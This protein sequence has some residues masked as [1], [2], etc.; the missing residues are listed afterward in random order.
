[1][2]G[3]DV[4]VVGAGS[5]GCVLAAR[6]T[7]N[8]D[9]QVLLLEAGPD[10]PSDA[11]PS[12]IRDAAV[13]AF[14]H[15]WGYSSE[16]S[17]AG[18]VVD[19]ARGRL[20]GGCSAVN[21]T[22]ALRGSPADYDRWRSS[23]ARG[24]GWEEV[25]PVF[26]R[27]ES[28]L[29][30]GGMPWH[31][32]TGPVPIRR[33][34]QDEL[35]P[36]PLEFLEACQRAGHDA[37]ADH[38]QPGAIGAGLLPVNAVG[39]VRQSAALTYL[40]AAR[41]RPNLSVRPHAQV[42]RLRFKGR[43]ARGVVLAGGEVLHADRVV[44]A[45][46]AYASPAILLRSGIGPADALRALGIPVVSDLPGVGHNLQDHPASTIAFQPAGKSDRAFPAYQALLTLR[47]S[48]W[49]EPEPDLQ[50]VV[51]TARPGEGLELFA[52]L[53]RP[54]SRG[55]VELRDRGALTPPR[56]TT[57]FLQEPRD[58]PRLIEALLAARELAAS[59]SLLPWTRRPAAPGSQFD[60][61]AGSIGAYVDCEHWSYFHPVGT[62]AIGEVVDHEGRVQ[63][64][65]GV[66]VVDASILPDIPSANTNLPTMMA[67]ER[68]ADAISALD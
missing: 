58:R 8:R 60:W 41:A 67:A 19:L 14:T 1:V 33:Y 59:A 35:G 34:S 50:V 53:L 22:F 54:D 10:Y 18:H 49:R 12:E 13:P 16:P 55:S 4:V 32:S 52:A 48:G 46:G 37:V 30:F 43:C 68:C 40:Q 61:S 25:L 51:R 21:A 20:V 26:R 15:G 24:W 2:S 29:D 39:G 31:G 28:D 6:L 66:R 17:A 3:H 5:A 63:G 64:V 11:L 27:L 56:V 23:G 42:D 36:G 47:S 57:G 62:C 7:E 38:N 45:T 65:E 44:L 9:R